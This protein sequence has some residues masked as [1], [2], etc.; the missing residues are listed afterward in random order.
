[1]F[2][3]LILNYIIIIII[4]LMSSKE[5]RFLFIYFVLPRPFNVWIH[6]FS[7]YLNKWR[8]SIAKKKTSTAQVKES[9]P[10]YPPTPCKT[11]QSTNH[12]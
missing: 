2:Q 4:I 3:F 8:K 12:N 9:A 6:T 10:L 7:F 1:M 11:Q 5:Y